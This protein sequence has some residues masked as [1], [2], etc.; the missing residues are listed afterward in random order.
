[1]KRKLLVFVL[2]LFAKWG[3]RCELCRHW[4]KEYEWAW[5]RCSLGNEDKHGWDVC[6]EIE[7]RAKH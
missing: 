7:I 5:G 1:M 4:S 6:R 2:D 3:M